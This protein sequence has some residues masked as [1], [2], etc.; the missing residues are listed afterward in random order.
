MADLG[1]VWFVGKDVA[2]I[3][4]Y[5]DTDYATRTHCKPLEIL[6]AGETSG[7]KCV[8]SETAGSKRRR[9]VPHFSPWRCIVCRQGRC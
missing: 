7:L 3:L 1:G 5:K 2:G 9:T 6:K 4:G 8:P